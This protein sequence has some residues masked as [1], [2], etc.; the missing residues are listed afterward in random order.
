[1]PSLIVSLPQNSR[2]QVRKSTFVG[3]SRRSYS[4][5]GSKICGKS[6]QLVVREFQ[7][8]TKAP[9]ASFQSAAP[10]FSVIDCFSGKTDGVYNEDYGAWVSPEGLPGDQTE[11]IGLHR[12]SAP[13][14]YLPAHGGSDL[15]AFSLDIDVQPASSSIDDE[16]SFRPV[17]G[18]AR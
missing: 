10:Y 6:L 2:S 5:S 17:R 3:G 1:M 14:A 12:S 9:L 7:T 4:F 13:I 15:P 16:T 11:V 18:P 8:G